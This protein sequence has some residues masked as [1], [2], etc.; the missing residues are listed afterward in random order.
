M[1]NGR[2]TTTGRIFPELEKKI[3]IGLYARGELL[4]PEELALTYAVPAAQMR[5]I[6]GRL[7]QEKLVEET[8]EGIAVIGI[9]REDME[10]MYEIRVRLEGM[11]AARAAERVSP[12]Q[13][14][15][16]R[17]ILD[18][19]H[20]YLLEGNEDRYEEFRNLDSAFHGL[21]YASSGSNVL[22]DLLTSIHKKIGKF[23]MASVRRSG[24]AK[25]ALAEHEAIYNAL[26]AHD[27]GEA[28]QAALR[29]V[30]KAKE[31]MTTIE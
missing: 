8:P 12:E 5:Q 15:Q 11:A 9:S 13:L 23:R 10:D 6:I 28:V 1:E 30:T 7:I 29:H 4:N 18:L 24:R 14:R 16:M 31:N 17:E 22:G 25:I 26:A 3:L 19:Q 27:A 20:A 2:I 21:F